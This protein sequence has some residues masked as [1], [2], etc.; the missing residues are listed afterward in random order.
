VNIEVAV[1]GDWR[2]LEDGSTL[3]TL[4]RDEP[5]AGVAVAR[6]GEVVPRSEWAVTVLAHRDRLELVR[7]V[8]GG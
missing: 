1:N 4:L 3:A 2:V 7:P 5:P 8:Q 6:N